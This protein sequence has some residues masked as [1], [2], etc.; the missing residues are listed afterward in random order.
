MATG[1]VVAIGLGIMSDAVITVGASVCINVEDGY[2][3]V[4]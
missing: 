1:P 2:S 3:F 4:S